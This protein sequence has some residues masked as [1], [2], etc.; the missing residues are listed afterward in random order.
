MVSMVQKDHLKS[1]LFAW[2]HHVA[3]PSTPLLHRPCLAGNPGGGQPHKGLHDTSK[4]FNW[5]E[6]F[7]ST[8]SWDMMHVQ[9]YFP[10]VELSQSTGRKKNKFH[11]QRKWND[12]KIGDFE[13]GCRG[14]ARLVASVALWVRHR[15]R[16]R[17]HGSKATRTGAGHWDPESSMKAASSQAVQAIEAPWS[18]IW[19]LFHPKWRADLDWSCMAVKVSKCPNVSDFQSTRPLSFYPISSTLQR[20][21][22]MWPRF[23]YDIRVQESSWNHLQ[24][25]PSTH[26]PVLAKSTVWLTL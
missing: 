23:R 22:S 1:L 26:I 5:C 14:C 20:T 25:W 18:K 7:V 9:T 2:S 16:A 15:S 6:Y 3:K 17:A 13:R 10:H 4:E 8:A 21:R 24:D 19:V 11:V 12:L